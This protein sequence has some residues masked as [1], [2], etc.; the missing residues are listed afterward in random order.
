[1]FSN[2]DHVQ[3]D[4]DFETAIAI[5]IAIKNKSKIIA[6]RFSFQNRIAILIAKSIS[7]FQIKI[8]QRLENAFLTAITDGT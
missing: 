6:N 5:M 2:Q 3:P 8:G 4:P 7:D 1:M